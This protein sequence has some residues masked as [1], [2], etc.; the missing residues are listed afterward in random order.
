VE[1]FAQSDCVI[2]AGRHIYLTDVIDPQG[3]TL[4][5]TYDP[6]L[7]LPHDAARALE[8]DGAIGRLHGE[9]LVTVGN[10]TPVAT[11]R[12]FGVEWAAELRKAG[13]QAAILT[14]T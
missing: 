6:S 5:F 9:F 7:L 8:Q 3:L 12:R 14:A 10:G 2:P 4:H 1:V 13:V 11:A